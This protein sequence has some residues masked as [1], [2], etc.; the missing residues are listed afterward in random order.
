M[1]AKDHRALAD[2][3]SCLSSQTRIAVTSLPNDEIAARVGTAA[4]IRKLGHV[5]VPHISA[6][7][8][9][10]AE[11]F[12]D[13]LRQLASEAAIDRVF[14]VGGDVR[15]PVGPYP[16]AISLI[17]TGALA[18]YGLRRVGI[19][20]YPDGHPAIP[21]SELR[22]VLLEKVRLLRESG[23]EPI[24]ATQFSFDIDAIL[25]WL[26]SL[27]QDGISSTVRI[28]VPGPTSA[29]SLLAFAAR[30]GVSAST[31]VLK[32]YGVSITQLL[33]SVGPDNLLKEF[34]QRLDAKRHGHVKLHF[35]PFGGLGATARWAQG[36]LR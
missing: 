33:S 2:A 32:K 28:G 17:A 13:L 27:R 5:P 23:I 31:S 4:L 1:T 9:S 8:L 35:Y 15:V 36:L 18:R 11:E 24:V 16:D 19:A 12:D 14:V 29:K 30:C 3:A 7:R 20:G 34:G 25:I 10:S 22:R 6:R 26:E 21:S